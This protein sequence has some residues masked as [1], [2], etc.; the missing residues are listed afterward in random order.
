MGWVVGL[1]LAV[2][3]LLLLRILAQPMGLLLLA[4]LRAAGGY[5]VLWVLNGV[6][7]LVGLHLPLN[8]VTA[9]MVGILGLPGILALYLLQRIQSL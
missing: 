9:L 8:P 7:L 2:A 3:L 5:A 4:L 1:G 6:G